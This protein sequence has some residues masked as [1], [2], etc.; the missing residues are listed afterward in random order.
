MSMGVFVT[1]PAL[2]GSYPRKIIAVAHIG[3]Y[4]SAP[5]SG[6][7]FVRNAAMRG[8]TGGYNWQERVQVRQW[9][10]GLEANPLPECEV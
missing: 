7:F 5:F 10:E 2:W 1:V 6:L 8:T 9:H 4:T 3:S